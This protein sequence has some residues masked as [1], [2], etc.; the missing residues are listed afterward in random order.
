MSKRV[1]GTGLLHNGPTTERDEEFFCEFH[2]DANA[3]TQAK[4]MTANEQIT[5][6]ANL[7]EFGLAVLDTCVNSVLLLLAF[8]AISLCSC[9]T[10]QNRRDLY[11]EQKVNGPY[12]RLLKERRWKPLYEEPRA[13][14]TSSVPIGAP[15]TVSDG[16]SVKPVQGD[17]L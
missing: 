3:I 5:I 10:L 15:D 4:K 8:L 13:P 9:S 2:D 16:K 1:N 7:T 17:V 11:S 6:S 12:T 14:K